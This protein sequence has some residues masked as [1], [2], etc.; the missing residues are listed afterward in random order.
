M[1]RNFLGRSFPIMISLF[2]DRKLPFW[3]ISDKY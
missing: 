3:E 1:Q 2:T